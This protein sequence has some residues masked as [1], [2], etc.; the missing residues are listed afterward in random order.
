MDHT[1]KM[2][3]VPEDAYT[4]LLN[5]QQQ[6]MPPAAQQLSNLDSELKS[7]L[8]NPGLSVEEK[9]D[10]YN[11]TFGRYKHLQR[12][13][14]Q[15]PMIAPPLV[16]AETQV[17]PRETAEK[18]TSAENVPISQK[19]LLQSLPKGLRERGKTFLKHLERKKEIIRWTPRGELLRDGDPIPDSSIADL[20]H[21]FTRDRPTVK[22]PAGAVELAQQLQDTNIPLEAVAGNSFARVGTLNYD[23]A[24]LFS[25]DPPP[26]PPATPARDLWA[27]PEQFAP[28]QG[29]PLRERLRQQHK[30]HGASPSKEGLRCQKHS[31]KKKRA[32]LATAADR[33]IIEDILAARGKAPH[34]RVEFREFYD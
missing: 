7:I 29:T 28:P 10:R 34:Q 9:Y 32:P 16:N 2:L 20:V 8:A 11:R 4:N 22:P 31:S 13:L 5:Q 6:L 25:P 21:F 26:P 15:P 27:T 19:I 30:A 33:K 14:F 24:T 3:M 12:P 1:T 23:L 18:G 17:V